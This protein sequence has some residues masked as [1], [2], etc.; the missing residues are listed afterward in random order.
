[1]TAGAG[2]D[3]VWVRDHKADTVDCGAGDDTV[4]A[5]K[6]DTLTNCEH[7]KVRRG[8]GK[9]DKPKPTHPPHP[10]Q[11]HPLLG[12]PGIGK[13][14]GPGPSCRGPPRAGRLCLRVARC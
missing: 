14:A 1:M 8:H 10:A 9:P 2:D 3:V 7:A 11:A 4:I 13:E 5:D 6:A 12:A